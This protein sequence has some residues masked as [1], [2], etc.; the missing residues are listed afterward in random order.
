MTED[1][2][3]TNQRE[4]TGPGYIAKQYRRIRVE[5]GWKTLKERIG[6]GYVNDNGSICFRPSGAQLIEG[7]VHLF[8]REKRIQD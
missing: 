8:L 7:D 1:N 3:N 2:A 4:H 6:V 5:D